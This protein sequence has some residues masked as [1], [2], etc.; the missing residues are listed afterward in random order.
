MAC[1]WTEARGNGRIICY[2]PATGTT[3][4][5]LRGLKFP[6]G[7]CIASDGQSILFAETSVA[8]SSAYWFDGPRPGSRDGDGQSA[9]FPT[10]SISLDEI[11]G[12]RWSACA[13][14]RSIWPGGCPASASGWANGS[15]RR[16]AFP[17]T[18]TNRMRIKFNE[19]G[20][21]A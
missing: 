10:T 2:N 11:I 15:D 18:S 1:R 12:W 5:A 8:R 3:H 7:I 4:T 20:E 13:A 21:V 19:R 6:N 16:V 14:R 9:G 17:E